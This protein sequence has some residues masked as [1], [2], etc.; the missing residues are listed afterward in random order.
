MIVYVHGLQFASGTQVLLLVFSILKEWQNLQGW[1][2][3]Y[4]PID[5]VY[6][7]ITSVLNE[8]QNGNPKAF[9]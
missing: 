4:H 1:K 3:R 7:V 2:Y 5:R 9:K 6:S 8:V